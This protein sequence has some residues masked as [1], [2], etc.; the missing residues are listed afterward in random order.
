M[1]FPKKGL[2]ATKR[3]GK[4]KIT[5]ASEGENQR[6]GEERDGGQHDAVFQNPEN[7]AERRGNRRPTINLRSE[8][9]PGL[10]KKTKVFQVI[11]WGV[12]KPK[13]VG[14]STKGQL[15]V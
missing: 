15:V 3:I 6:W 2:R 1:W 11:N 4:K 13:N 9:G 12:R 14:R 10:R 8:E 7:G 5:D